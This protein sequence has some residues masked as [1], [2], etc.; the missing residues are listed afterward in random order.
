MATKERL[1]KLGLLK[2][3]KCELCG[4]DVESL[5]HIIFNCKH[6]T[7]IWAEICKWMQLKNRTVN[8]NCIKTWTH[9][10]G[11]RKGLFKAVAAETIYAIWAQRNNYIFHRDTYTIDSDRNVKNIV[12]VIVYR[13]RKHTIYRSKIAM[14][15]M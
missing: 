9:G 2:D 14:L 12:D 7:I 10:K 1:F 8:L 5:E 4:H 11:W 3:T 15:L 6:S 13:G